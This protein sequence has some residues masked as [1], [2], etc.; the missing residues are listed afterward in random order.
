MLGT[1]LSIQ[2]WPVS[3]CDLLWDMGVQETGPA[4]V[5]EK[6]GVEQ[7]RYESQ[8]GISPWALC[9]RERKV[10]WVVLSLW[11]LLLAWQSSWATSKLW[12]EKSGQGRCGEDLPDVSGTKS[13]ADLAESSSATHRVSSED[14]CCPGLRFMARAVWCYCWLQESLLLRICEFLTFFFEEKWEERSSC[15]YWLSAVPCVPVIEGEVGEVHLVSQCD[16]NGPVGT[17]SHFIV[18]CL[19]S[20]AI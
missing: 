13:C 15:V 19:G 5:H 3:C 6:P 17:T 4:E 10:S 11:N 14:P 2:S 12:L 7:D 1:P 20:D 18:L 9:R 16:T 8:E